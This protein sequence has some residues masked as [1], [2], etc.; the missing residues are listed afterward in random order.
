MTRTEVTPLT[1][2]ASSANER[3]VTVEV[4][5]QLYA[6]PALSVREVIQFVPPTRVPQAPPAMIGVINLRGQIVP[7]LDL[8]IVLG[9]PACPAAGRTCIVVVSAQRGDVTFAAGL[10]VDTALE[11]IRLAAKDIEAHSPTAPLF[12]GA[13]VSG[14][15]HAKGA[16]TIVLDLDRL[17][18]DALEPGSVAA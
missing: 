4:A 10:V 17:L 9:M 12:P 18:P 16:L 6:V 11:V 13:Y 5:G 1:P 15:A 14:I 7:V 3:H 8:R 2:S